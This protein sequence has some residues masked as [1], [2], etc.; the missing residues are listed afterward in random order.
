MTSFEGHGLAFRACRAPGEADQ[1]P[2]LFPWRPGPYLPVGPCASAPPARMPRPQPRSGPAARPC[3][4]HAY[5]RGRVVLD[6]RGASGCGRA[7]APRT[8]HRA[9]AVGRG[10]GPA[11]CRN[12][13]DGVPGSHFDAPHIAPQPHALAALE[14]RDARLTH[15]GPDAAVRR[16]RLGR[17]PRWGASPPLP[18]ASPM[19]PALAPS[20][21]PASSRRSRQPTW[22]TSW[23]RRGGGE[24]RLP[25]RPAHRGQR[26]GPDLLD[27]AP[28]QPAPAGRG[29]LRRPG[30]R[31]GAPLRRS[32]VRSAARK[33]APDLCRGLAGLRRHLQGIATDPTS[34][35]PSTA[36]ATAVVMRCTHLPSSRKVATHSRAG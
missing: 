30:L 11:R 20:S 34:T 33:N 28:R 5:R 19:L 21:S 36:A 35:S 29:G 23:G 25:S 2:V 13:P 9:P 17:S 27:D 16:A 6:G 31:A 15:A 1:V 22:P 18:D 24:S 10:D 12:P 14:V 3:F 7:I 8:G 4:L 26:G 32:R